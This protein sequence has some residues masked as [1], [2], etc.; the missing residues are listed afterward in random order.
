MRA[1]ELIKERFGEIMA[2][3]I[4][5]SKA[6]WLWTQLLTVSLKLGLPLSWCNFC[7][8]KMCAAVGARK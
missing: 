2:N 4:K 7:S 1:K 6:E 3:K 5:Q 8:R